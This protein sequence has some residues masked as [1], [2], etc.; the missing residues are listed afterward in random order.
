MLHNLK[1][2]DDINSPLQLSTD[3]LNLNT[4]DKIKMCIQKKKL[5][6]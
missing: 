4:F 5:Y 6:T 1:T 2:N 3:A